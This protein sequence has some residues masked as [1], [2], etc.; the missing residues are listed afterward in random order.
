MKRIPNPHKSIFFMYVYAKI[1]NKQL[2][3]IMHYLKQLKA[4]K[5]A[6]NFPVLVQF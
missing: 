3:A 5:E 1:C 4:C 2:Y 6:S